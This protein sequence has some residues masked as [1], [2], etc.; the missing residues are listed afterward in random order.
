[1]R[2]LIVLALLASV[3]AVAGVTYPRVT[4]IAQWQQTGSQ[5]LNASLEGIANNIALA[6]FSYN[7]GSILY[8]IVS[9]FT[10]GNVNVS[11]HYAIVH[12]ATGI[13]LINLTYNGTNFY[14]GAANISTLQ[15]ILGSAGTVLSPLDLAVNITNSF[16]VFSGIP[17]AAQLANEWVSIMTSDQIIPNPPPYPADGGIGYFLGSG[18]TNLL[19]Y[20]VWSLVRSTAT[21][22]ASGLA[23][24]LDIWSG[25]AGQLT[26]ATG[27]TYS[28]F[29]SQGDTTNVGSNSAFS[30]TSPAIT[31]QAFNMGNLYVALRSTQYGAPGKGLLRGQ[32]LQTQFV[33]VPT[34]A[35]PPPPTTTTSSIGGS[36]GNTSAAQSLAVSLVSVLAGLFVLALF[37]L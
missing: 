14:Y 9:N 8:W 4:H 20:F 32:I 28:F 23:S 22:P 33:A 19:Y 36:S 17:K 11:S 16:G 10:S 25:G 12:Q 7:N 6:A 35:P 5:N 29:I 37:S 13:A 18:T 26:N 1:M 15:R 31:P 27:P 24:N 2:D 3:A 30:P 21:A 34:P